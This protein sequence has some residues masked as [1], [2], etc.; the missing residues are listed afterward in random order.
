MLD[1]V[2]NLIFIQIYMAT[3]ENMNS[4]E[5]L[6][7]Q[8]KW[9][10][11]L[12]ELKAEV[13]E[14]NKKWEVSW[15]RLIRDTDKIKKEWDTLKL[16]RNNTTYDIAS[17][18]S[19][20]SKGVSE[21]QKVPTT[22]KE[23]TVVAWDSISKILNTEFG[24]GQYKYGDKNGP[25]NMKDG[26]DKILIWEKLTLETDGKTREKEMYLYTL[27]RD[28]NGKKE[29]ITFVSSKL[30]LKG[31]TSTETIDSQST[32][33]ATTDVST[34]KVTSTPNAEVKVAPINGNASPKITPNGKKSTDSTISWIAGI[35]SFEAVTP[36]FKN[37]LNSDAKSTKEAPVQPKKNEERNVS[38][39]QE[40]S[41]NVESL[42]NIFPAASTEQLKNSHLEAL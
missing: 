36:A 15:D 26:W 41:T 29:S 10:V 30:L 23:I 14:W 38:E 11:L 2:C 25:S 4:S 3:P 7:G 37:A 39:K 12:N 21:E 20:M 19:E 1:Y 13:S 28:K 34:K 24:S 6:V 40:N 33:K 9:S 32:K 5:V 27:S 18:K 31:V 42:K 22:K 8:K 16:I 17:L 35:P